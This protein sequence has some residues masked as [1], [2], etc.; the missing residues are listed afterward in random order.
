MADL[1]A[2]LGLRAGGFGRAH[3]PFERKLRCSSI[4]MLAGKARSDADNGG[5]GTRTCSDV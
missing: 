1:F 3:A 4:M 5:K 2:Q